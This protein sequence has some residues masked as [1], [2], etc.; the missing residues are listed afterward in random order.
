MFNMFLCKSL[1]WAFLSQNPPHLSSFL[2]FYICSAHL[3]TGNVQFSDGACA[4]H[5]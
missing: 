3:E 4:Y 5:A 2:F 1:N